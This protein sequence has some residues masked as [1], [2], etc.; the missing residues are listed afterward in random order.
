MKF[1][2]IS[3]IE[4]QNN[5]R[6]TTAS[7]YGLVVGKMKESTI[8][9]ASV[10]FSNNTF[11][12]LE[13]DFYTGENSAILASIHYSRMTETIGSFPEPPFPSSFE[14]DLVM[15]TFSL[16]SGFRYHPIEDFHPFF[17]Q[18]SLGIIRMNPVLETSPRYLYQTFDRLVVGCVAP[19]LNSG[20]TVI[21]KVGLTTIFMPE[22]T[23]ADRVGGFNKF[24]FGVNAGY[25]SLR[26]SI[27]SGG[28]PAVFFCSTLQ[29]DH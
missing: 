12:S 15:E 20:I 28:S 16:E 18:G 11:W 23:N 21:P 26:L 7:G 6:I 27:V 17:V 3:A 5:E 1:M 10:S 25:E 8:G 24:E 2:A 19:L 4:S 22:Y 9:G 14:L 13:A 29:D